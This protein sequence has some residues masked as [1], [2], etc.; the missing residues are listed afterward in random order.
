MGASAVKARPPGNAR[1]SLRAPSAPWRSAPGESAAMFRGIIEGTAPVVAFRPTGE[2]AR[3]VVD[4]APIA[5]EIV[6]G[7]SIA[8]NGACLTAVERRGGE[9]AFDLAGETLRRTAFRSLRGGERVNF[10]R[11]MRLDDRLDGHLVQGHVDGVG[12][13]ASFDARHGDDWLVVRAE[14]AQLAAMVPKG[15]IAVDG[16]SLTIAE[17]GTDQFAC[18]I[19]PH[20]R[21]VTHL[22]HRRAGDPVNLECD[23]LIKWLA[24]LQERGQGGGL[25]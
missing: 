23:V 2:G 15:S 14:P 10:E 8:I 20:T 4:L 9:V 13:I 25:R 12:V 3:L 22:A 11:A 5:A 6:I 7:Q 24:Q 18:T 21:A 1:V 19:V 16:I 17:L